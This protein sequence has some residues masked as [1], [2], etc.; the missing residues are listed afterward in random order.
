MQ[1]DAVV[2]LLAEFLDRDFQLA[3]DLIDHRASAAGA[4]VVHRR[5][6]FLAAAFVVVLEDDDLGVLPAQLDDGIHLRMLLLH[7][8]RHRRHFLHKF[9]ADQLGQH[10]AARPGDEHA[11]VAA[12]HTDFRLDAAQKFEGL[13][14]LLGLVA[15]VILPENFVGGG[16]EDHRLHRRRAHI[17][18]NHE[19]IFAIVAMHGVPPVLTMKTAVGW[20]GSA[21]S[22]G[23]RSPAKGY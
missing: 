5:D 1:L 11:C 4:L 22:T 8:E 12:V 20:K 6:F 15:L 2:A 9:R 17:Q 7:R 23:Q 3:V 10:A 19:A 13:L 21:E 18:S 16:V 14:G